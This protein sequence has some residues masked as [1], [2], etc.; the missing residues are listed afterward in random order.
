MPLLLHQDEYK[1]LNEC[2]QLYNVKNKDTE[3][4]KVARDTRYSSVLAFYQIEMQNE[5]EIQLASG[6][7]DQVLSYSWLDYTKDELIAH[8]KAVKYDLL[9]RSF[10]SFDPTCENSL[11]G[12]ID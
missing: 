11:D 6:A 4:T 12:A 2:H 9:G 3:V 1:D 8:K 10:L 7:L 5:Y